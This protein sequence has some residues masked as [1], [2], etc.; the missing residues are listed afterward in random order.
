MEPHGQNVLIGIGEDGLPNGKFLHRD[1]GGFNVD[2]GFRKEK[3]KPMPDSLPYARSMEADYY[4]DS[5]LTQLRGSLGTHFEGNFLWDLEHHLEKWQ[6]EGTLG[7]KKIEL[8]T[9]SKDMWGAFETEYQN[10]TGLT[11]SFPAAKFSPGGKASNEAFA[12]IMQ[13]GSKTRRRL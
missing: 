8:G 6:A 10:R 12:A 4:Q 5:H 11:K 7:G 9:F 3:G 1:F 2:L 13:E